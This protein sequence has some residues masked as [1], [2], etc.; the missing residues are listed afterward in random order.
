MSYEDLKLLDELRRNG[1][2]TEEEY[3][4]EK[5]KILNNQNNSFSKQPFFGLMENS[6]LLLMHL[7]Q[8]LGFIV[9]GF[10]FAFQ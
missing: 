6:Y 1:G 9:V 3:Q 8:F 5:A 2:I 7:S 10:G 4:R